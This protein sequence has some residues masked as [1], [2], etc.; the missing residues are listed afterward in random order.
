MPRDYAPSWS[1]GSITGRIDFLPEIEYF[2]TFRE[3]V[4]IH[5]ISPQ[6]SSANPYGPGTGTLSI[7][8][9]MVPICARA[10]R[11]SYR[12]FVVK[13]PSFESKN[14]PHDYPKNPPWGYFEPDID[15]LEEEIGGGKSMY[16][17]IVG[18]CCITEKR[19]KETLGLM[20]TEEPGAGEDLHYRRA[21][22][23]RGGG[24]F[25]MSRWAHFGVKRCVQIK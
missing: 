17:L 3:S 23:F 10:R 18:T 15:G 2:R 13:P 12:L 1:F 24:G 4:T 7:E 5:S 11:G 16:L 21:G 22:V 6:L 14:P 8:G 25:V 20:L 9:Y 19:I